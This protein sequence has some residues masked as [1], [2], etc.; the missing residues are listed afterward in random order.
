MASARDLPF[1][2]IYAAGI[3][4]YWL[5]IGG[6]Q[7][8]DRFLIPLF[9]MGLA[10]LLRHISVHD[11]SRVRLVLV[12]LLLCLHLAPLVA[13]TRFQFSSS[14]YD[15]WITLGAYLGEW[16]KGRT[17]AVHAAGKIP[18]FS[19][20][21]TLDMLGLNEPVIARKPVDFFMPGHNKYDADYVLAKKPDLITSF[22]DPADLDL[23]S[24]LWRDKYEKAGYRIHYL[25][26]GKEDLGIA[27]VVDVRGLHKEEI[28][29]M[30]RQGLFYAV[31]SRSDGQAG[32]SVDQDRLILTFA[33][34]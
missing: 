14:K 32:V 24:G 7:L 10:L 29:R 18:F 23:Y 5:Y 33:Q 8:G 17:L 19:G 6:D 21:K 25:V 34:R 22:I 1:E 28:K 27:N 15:M 4:S 12:L 20:L 16:E 30:V 9:P 13:D 2:V 26:S 31:L 11:R 3:L